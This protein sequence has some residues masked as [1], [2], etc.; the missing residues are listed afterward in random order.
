MKLKK[1][2]LGTV[3]LS[4][5]NMALAGNGVVL[6]TPLG[7]TLGNALGAALGLQLGSALPIDVGGLL[8]VATVSLLVGIRIVR[9]KNNQ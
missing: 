7:I 1:L 6:G 2:V 3:S 9:R 8:T 5:T 4:L